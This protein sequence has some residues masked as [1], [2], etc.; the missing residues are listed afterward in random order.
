VSVE[1]DTLKVVNRN[2]AKV[3]AEIHQDPTSTLP[4]LRLN[5]P[6]AVSGPING[7]TG[8][9]TAPLVGQVQVATSATTTANA[10]AMNTGGWVFDVRAYGAKGDGQVVSDG[11]IASS[12]KT[13][14]CSTSHPFKAADV[15]KLVMVR[16][17]AATGVT[18]LVTTIATYVDSSHVTLTAAAGTTVASGGLVMWATDDTAA[19]QAAINAGHAFATASAAASLYQVYSPPGSG[20]FYG[21]G[22]PLVT[23]GATLGNGQLTIPVNLDTANGITCQIVG[24]DSGAKTRHWNQTTPAMSGSTWV[25]FAVF[26]SGTAQ[27]NSA[28]AAGTPAVISGPTGVNG[29]GTSALLYS[30]VTVHMRNMS[31]LTAHS[32]NG[33]T[34][35]A[36]NLH[37][38]ARAI[39]E[40]FSYGTTGTVPNSDYNSPVGFANGNSIGV[41]MPAN[42][43]NAMSTWKRVICQGGYTYGVYAT[44]H[45]NID[46]SIILYCWSGF[47][48]VGTYGDGGSGVGALH[49][50]NF[51]LLAVEGCT[52]IVRI[53][54]PG[55]SGVGPV[56]RGRLDTEGNNIFDD[57]TTGTSLASSTGQVFMA[58]AGNAISS[59]S[60]MSLQVID[61]RTPPGPVATPAYSL[62][63]AQVNAY[64]RWATVILNGGTVT[65]VKVSALMG[66]ASAPA[67]STVWS[68]ALAAPITIRIPPGGWWEIDGSVKPTVNT[69]ILD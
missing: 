23:G 13:L 15:G 9:S 7:V 10:S 11:A 57:T 69:W 40:D 61:D 67:M 36:L 47:C 38:C 65:A 43:N 62:A 21:I 20:A 28:N 3:A 34:Y 42:G 54:S 37:G 1:G 66:G 31:L 68:G 4:A 8:P 19:I 29:Y 55:S 48:P 39:L 6:L 59:T 32:A 45:M 26:A 12:G 50:V 64:W 33:L 46:E 51:P 63:T 5:G 18:T 16:G 49:A 58:G 22:G 44:E 30:N 17:A 25:S 2:P 24:V 56:L 60:G 14:T 35:S 27:N 53:I 41:L 52:Q